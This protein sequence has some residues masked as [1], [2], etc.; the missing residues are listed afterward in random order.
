MSILTLIGEHFNIKIDWWPCQYLHY[1]VA[2]S[3]FTL[4]SEHVNIWWPLK[5]IQ[6]MVTI[7]ILTMIGDLV[8]IHNKLWPCSAISHQLTWPDDLVPRMNSLQ[9][10]VSY[11]MIWDLQNSLAFQAGTA[12]NVSLSLSW[13]QSSQP[14]FWLLW[15]IF[16]GNFF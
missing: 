13:G 7:Y 14:F 1:L 4:I 16:F 8:N 9:N 3:I 6:L 2:M 11:T 12:K 15:P 10:M 5:Y